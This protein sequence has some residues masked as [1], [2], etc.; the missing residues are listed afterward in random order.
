MTL[1]EE[2]PGHETIEEASSSESTAIVARPVIVTFRVLEATA[3]L[4]PVGVSLLARQLDMPKTTVQRAL[5]ALEDLGYVYAHGESTRWAL[6][7]KS[8]QL[9]A[10]ARV[11]DIRAVAL[12]AMSELSTTTGESIQL[13]VLEVNR[14]VVIEKIDSRQAVRSH[15]D[16]GQRLHLHSSAAGK[17]LLAVSGPDVLDAIIAA[18]LHR[19]TSRTI[20]D[21]GQLRAELEA[22]RARGF[23]I[24]DRETREDVRAV[25][26]VIRDFNGQP[27]GGIGVS[28]PYHRLEGDRVED[29]GG[30]VVR[31]A[32]QISRHLAPPA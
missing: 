32:E 4:Q 24:N 28:A 26:A 21:E 9:G 13:T 12:P 11:M 31:A 1:V 8:F 22:T 2:E 5:R 29:L 30:L 6:T 10:T 14:L 23:G 25:G 20:V 16:L 7:L 3:E 19:N 27:R 15:V 17:A 18:G